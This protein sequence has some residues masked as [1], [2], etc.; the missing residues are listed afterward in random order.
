MA[1]YHNAGRVPSVND[2]SVQCETGKRKNRILNKLINN[3][4]YRLRIYIVSPQSVSNIIEN[5]KISTA[6]WEKCIAHLLYDA[7]SVYHL[8]F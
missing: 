1:V 6:Q 7:S 3:N 4:I 8:R 2:T 5:G